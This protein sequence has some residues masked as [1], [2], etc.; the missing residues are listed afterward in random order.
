MAFIS[1]L[2]KI[3]EKKG[4]F[5]KWIRTLS[6]ILVVIW[7]HLL[8]TLLH[9]VAVPTAPPQEVKVINITTVSV[10]LEWKP[11][12]QK[13][14]NGR[15]KGYKVFCVLSGQNICQF[16]LVYGVTQNEISVT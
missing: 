13:Q 10:Y 5:L 6:P 15:I 14:Q 1:K 7:L 8:I 3:A 4:T 16:P 12:P 11:P 2:A 9:V